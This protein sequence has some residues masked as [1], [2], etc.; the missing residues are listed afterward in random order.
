[1]V[2]VT[3]CCGDNLL[4]QALDNPSLVTELQIL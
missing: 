2:V 1:M 3:W 4:P